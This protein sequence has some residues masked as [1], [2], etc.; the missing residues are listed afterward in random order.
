MAENGEG[1]LQGKIEE[2]NG[3]DKWGKNGSA[4]CR[5]IPFPIGN[6]SS[7]FGHWHFLILLLNV[8]SDYC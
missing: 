4:V 2:G 8:D 7:H 3:W 1:H 6:V 5:P